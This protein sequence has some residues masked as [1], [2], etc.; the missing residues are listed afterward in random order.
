MRPEAE[1]T[2]PT[3]FLEDYAL[4]AASGVLPKL[5]FRKIG[6]AYIHG[7]TVEEHLARYVMCIDLANQL[8]D[9]CR[10]KLHERREW[11]ALELIKKVQASVRARSDWDLSEGEVGWVMHQLCMRMN[12]PAPHT[13]QAPDDV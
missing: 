13:P 8:A 9:Y 4:G 6:D 10:R 3:D 1:T 2:T 11:S 5:L 12:W 7:L